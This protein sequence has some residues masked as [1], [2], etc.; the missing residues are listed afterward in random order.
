MT[1]SAE[2]FLD[3]VMCARAQLS[4][5]RDDEDLCLH[6]AA[7]EEALAL[8]LAVAEDLVEAVQKYRDKK[9]KGK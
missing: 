5:V 6:G 8:T 2:K 9:V 1:K 4:T 3:A 7:S